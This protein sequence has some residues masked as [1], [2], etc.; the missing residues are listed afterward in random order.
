MGLD[1][2]K[3]KKGVQKSAENLRQSVTDTT[4]KLPETIKDHKVPG[5]FKDFAQKGQNAFTALKSKG[6][7]A[8][9]QQREKRALQ[10]EA[11]SEAL[12]IQNEQEIVLSIKDS[13]RLIYCLIIADG[14]VSDEEKHK[15]CELWQELDPEFSSYQVQLIDEGNHLLDTFSEDED[16]YYD[17]IH[18]HV[19]EII[20]KTS[21]PK[22]SGIRGK[23][24][25]W[26][27]LTVAYSEGE[28]S[29]NEKRLLRFIAKCLGVDYAILLEMEHTVRT[30][31]AIEAEENWL[32]NTHRSYAVVEERVN[33]LTER[34][35]TIM[36]GIR[37]LM[38]D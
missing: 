5:S 38:V 1:F 24:L 12:Q 22:E 35:N 25:V 37:T 17:N 32:K 10:K 33:E 20:H 6:E 16:D 28:Y 19:S 2:N 31:L 15:F 8:I 27:L 9:A 30:L 34:K 18:N 23:I 36:L 4:E 13:L 29:S 14:I 3:L 7:E 26:D 11:V 21:A